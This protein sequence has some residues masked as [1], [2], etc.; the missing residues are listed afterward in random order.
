MTTTAYSLFSNPAATIAAPA[1]QQT[2][3]ARMRLPSVGSYLLFGRIVAFN[4]GPSYT[5]VNSS[6]T[7]LDGET[8]LDTATVTVSSGY[9]S[10]VFLQALLVMGAQDA[11]EIVD[12]RCL[13]GA[14]LTVNSVSLNAISVDATVS[15]AA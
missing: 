14:A 7:T 13:S 3:L 5:N 10:C 15:A 11:N 6:L 12:I 9:L 4:T 2:V 8:I 1:N